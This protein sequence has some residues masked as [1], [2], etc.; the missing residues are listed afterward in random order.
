MMNTSSRPQVAAWGNANGGS[1]VDDMALTVYTA[2]TGRGFM[3]A[4]R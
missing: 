1:T 2:T 3:I 4:R